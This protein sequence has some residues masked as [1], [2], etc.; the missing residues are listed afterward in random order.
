M[1]F[2][3][4]AALGFLVG[5]EISLLLLINFISFSLPERLIINII[6]LILSIIWGKI[7]G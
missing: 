1:K 2:N 7:N 3:K 4:S 5:Y 6:G